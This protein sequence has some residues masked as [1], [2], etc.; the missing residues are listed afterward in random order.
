MRCCCR[1]RFCLISQINRVVT[2]VRAE[3][4]FAL[5]PL[6]TYNNNNKN[7]RNEIVSPCNTLLRIT[8]FV[9]PA[10]TR[11]RGLRRI[12][13][14]CVYIYTEY[15]LVVFHIRCGDRKAKQKEGKKHETEEIE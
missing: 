11:V 4:L 7:K 14:S 3:E 1:L 15:T 9:C 13:L 8:H 12:Y 10:A 5:R 6:R 2:V